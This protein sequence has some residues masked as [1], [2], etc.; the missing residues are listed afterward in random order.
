LALGYNRLRRFAT[1]RVRALERHV[2]ARFFQRLT[3]KTGIQLALYDPAT[4]ILRLAEITPGLLDYLLRFGFIADAI[5][6]LP[7]IDPYI[8]QNGLVVDV[9]GFRGVTSQWFARR[10][11]QVITFEPM[12]ESADSMR[13]LLKIRAIKNVDVHQI[14]LSDQIGQSELNIYEIKGH[15]SLGRVNTSKY[16]RSIQVSTTTLDCFAT[17]HGID[18]ID[19][20][21]IDVEGFE[22]EVLSGAV[23]L[24]RSKKI[25]ALVFESNQ[26]VLRSLG[27]TAQPVYDILASHSYRVMDLEGRLVSLTEFN[28]CEFADFFACPLPTSSDPQD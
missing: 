11:G 14:A 8:P 24:L 28:Q 20:L 23:Q 1:T 25:K 26:P 3:S 13:Q 18:S 16:L 21:K 7:K 2:A 27:K 10:A 9:G 6:W 5:P 19:L 17:E 4:D 12:P 22:F 15:N